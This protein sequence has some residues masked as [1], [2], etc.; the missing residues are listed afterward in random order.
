MSAFERVM[1]ELR[2]IAEMER[3]ERDESTYGLE[4]NPERD[5]KMEELYD[6]NQDSDLSD[7]Y[8][9]DDENEE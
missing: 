4:L 1:E 6:L 5:L 2:E 3:G 9:K 8:N 7:Q